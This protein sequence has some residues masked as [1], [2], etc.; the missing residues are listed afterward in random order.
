MNAEFSVA[1]RNVDE[2]HTGT[3]PI[4]VREFPNRTTIGNFAPFRTGKF[5]KN[6]TEWKYESCENGKDKCLS[7]FG[8]D[9]PEK[10]Q[11]IPV[12]DHESLAFI[13][14][15]SHFI[16]DHNDVFD[17]NVV[18]YLATIVDQTRAKQ[19]PINND[20]P[21]DC[22]KEDKFDFD[23][24]FKHFHRILP[25]SSGSGP[26]SWELPVV[27]SR[28][29]RMFP[30]GLWQMIKENGFSRVYL[31]VHWFFDAF[32]LGTNNRPDLT[33]DIGGVPLGL[34]IAENIFAEG[35]GKAPKKSSVGPRP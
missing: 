27:R 31:G 20:I 24:C 26:D 32:A 5:T 9:L 6:G 13:P 15:D 4:P 14:T 16:E 17:G 19:N 28:H 11:H 30:R 2:R 21:S 35:A 1:R 29:A 25:R 18:S 34:K 23:T 10:R 3:I 7:E 33:Q 22:K 12:L 8:N